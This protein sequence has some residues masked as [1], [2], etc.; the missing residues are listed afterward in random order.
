MEK[1]IILSTRNKKDAEQISTLLEGYAYTVE[2]TSSLEDL[3]KRLE[4][5]GCTVALLDLDSI[6]IENRKFRHLAIA[7]R[8][9][10]FLCMSERR[11]HPNLKEAISNHFYA[12]LAKPLDFD[13]LLYWLRCIED[14]TGNDE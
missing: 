7:N 4:K 11:V 12:C 10:D 14:T 6:P 2:I 8:K 9:T 5:H 13:E 3:G 1:T